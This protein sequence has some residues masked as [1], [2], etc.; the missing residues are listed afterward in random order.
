[1]LKHNQRSTTRVLMKSEPDPRV[2]QW[3]L[4]HDSEQMFR[5]VAVD[6]LTGSI[7]TQDFEGNVE[8]IDAEVWQQI[9]LEASE[10]PEDWTGRY[11]EL[12]IDRNDCS[13]TAV[14]PRG[15]RTS[16]ELHEPLE[17]WRKTLPPEDVSEPIE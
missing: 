8:E 15:W 14:A 17:S 2:G 11:D 16:L 9:E 1:M 7:E 4:R 3:Y 10:A 5:V 12:T 13:S 6:P